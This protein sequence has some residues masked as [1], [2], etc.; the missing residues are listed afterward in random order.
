MCVFS[1]RS[2]Q[3][4]TLG[5]VLELHQHFPGCF[6]ARRVT[7]G[8]LPGPL[9][10]TL[11]PS[12]VVHPL[13][14]ASGYPYQS[15]HGSFWTWPASLRCFVNCFQ[16]GSSS[17]LCTQHSSIGFSPWSVPHNACILMGRG[18]IHP[19]ITH[20]WISFLHIGSYQ[21]AVQSIANYLQ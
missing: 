19:H 18:W 8:S 3:R 12:P 15:S 13:P 10:V 2:V 17:H 11:R 16:T 9:E 6:L 14:L 20:R 1:T 21:A 7:A 5:K 4:S